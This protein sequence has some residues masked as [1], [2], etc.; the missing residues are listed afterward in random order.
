MRVLLP[1]KRGEKN[2]DQTKV[3]LLL[4][5]SLLSSGESSLS[6][7]PEDLD[8]E[9]MI[10]AISLLTSPSG[11]HATGEEGKEREKN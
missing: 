9:G 4:S 6:L 2:G 11:L 5:H 8:P 10:A 1:R 7:N 3:R